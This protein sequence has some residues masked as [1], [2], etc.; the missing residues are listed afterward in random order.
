M[1]L[2]V[3]NFNMKP[4]STAE[5]AVNSNVALV[6][7]SGVVNAVHRYCLKSYWPSAAKNVTTAANHNEEHLSHFPRPVSGEMRTR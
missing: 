7:C 2:T 4:E 3:A 6:F 5:H 1:R